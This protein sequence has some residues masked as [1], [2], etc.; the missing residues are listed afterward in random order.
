MF[1][2]IMK[3]ILI[4][5]VTAGN[6]HNACANAMKNELL[7]S[8]NAEVKVVDLLKSYST[9]LN[10]WVAD[11]GYGLAVSRL[12]RAYDYFY[13]KYMNFP[14]EKRYSCPSQS[15]VISTLNGLLNEILNFKPDVIYCTHFYASIAITDLKL[16][17]E[18]P[19]KCVAANLDY[20]NSPFWEAGIGVDY[21]AIPNEDFIEE[22]LF[23]GYERSQLL[24]I[25][26]PVDGRTLEPTDKTEARKKLGLDAETF[27]VLVMFGGGF[28]SGGYEIFKELLK[29]LKGKTAQI[30]VI[31][32]KNKK[33][34]KKIEHIKRR[35]ARLDHECG[36]KILNIGFTNEVHLYISAVDL[37]ICKC[38]GLSSTELIN[39][40]VPMLVTESLPAQEKHNLTYLKSKGVAFSFKD[41]D[42]LKKHIDCITANPQILSDMSKNTLALK[43]NAIFDL[44]EFILSQPQ[45]DYYNFKSKYDGKINKRAF[46]RLLKYA[47]QAEFSEI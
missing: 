30:I 33:G 37:A 9:K 12:P 14:P 29:A 23:E 7:K 13:N 41:A 36:I 43:R 2:S 38:G 6:G 5:T 39:K 10:V 21:F 18:L 3:K 11:K 35:I 46:K 44:A 34:F 8:G 31:N 19:C 32:G 24:P 15:T 1:G 40:G 22:F 45:A 16:A 28:W 26:L 47:E 17:Y 27:T 25:G 4:L 42:E 20:V